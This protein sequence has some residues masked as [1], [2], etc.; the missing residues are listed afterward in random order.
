LIKALLSCISTVNNFLERSSEK[1]P[2][3]AFKRMVR[4]SILSMEDTLTT[5]KIAEI[6][7][8]L[9]D[10][11]WHT[12]EEIQEKMKLNDNQMQ[13]IVGFLKEYNF[14]VVNE[15]REEI[16]LEETVRRFLIQKTTS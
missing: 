6:L 13:Q 3:K 12:L 11:Q 1:Q 15:K 2:H 4:K 8:L 7:E 10:E 14:I 16:R 5:S 9:G